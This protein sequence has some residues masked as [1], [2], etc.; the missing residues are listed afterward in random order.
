MSRGV[1]RARNCTRHT[2]AGAS[3]RS[4]ALTDSVLP[5]PASPCTHIIA[6]GA[7]C[8]LIPVRS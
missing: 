4:D 7:L 2:S 1:G 3:A 5:S 6:L 8:G